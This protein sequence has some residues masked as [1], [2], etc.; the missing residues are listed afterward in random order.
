MV[1]RKILKLLSRYVDHLKNNGIHLEDAFLYGSYC[2]GNH[3]TSS[4]IDVLLVLS[5]ADASSDALSGKI[6]RLSK[7]FDEKIE[8]LIIGIEKFHQDEVSPVLIN[9]RREAVSFL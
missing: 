9:I 3:K 8:P 6:W 1:E 7:E 4:D 5:E 2:T